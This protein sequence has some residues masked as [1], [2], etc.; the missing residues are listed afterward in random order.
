MVTNSMEREVKK[1]LVFTRL[2]YSKPAEWR[3]WVGELKL[4]SIDE[5]TVMLHK[6]AKGMWVGI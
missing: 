6:V 5:E 1:W 3:P 4:A 2:S